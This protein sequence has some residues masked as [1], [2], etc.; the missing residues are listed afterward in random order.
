MAAINTDKNNHVLPIFLKAAAVELTQASAAAIPVDTSY[1]MFDIDSG[2]AKAFTLADGTVPGQVMCL[3][4]LDTDGTDKAVIT[5]ANYVFSDNEVSTIN[6]I[7][8]GA[9]LIWLGDVWAPLAVGMATFA[10]S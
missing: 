6:N 8:E 2:G 3:H 10:A 7:G 9:T 1:I 5:V 4:G